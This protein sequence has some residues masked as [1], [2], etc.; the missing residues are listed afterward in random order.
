MAVTLLNLDDEREYRRSFEL[1]QVLNTAMLQ[2]VV[3]RILDNADP[4][5]WKV[6]EDFQD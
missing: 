3:K 4:D 5:V 6:A 1:A 2:Y